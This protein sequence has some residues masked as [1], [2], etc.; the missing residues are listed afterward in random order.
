MAAPPATSVAAMLV[1]LAVNPTA[2]RGR[3]AAAGREL[4]EEIRARGQ[5]VR[6]LAS[7]DA[8]GLRTLVGQAVAGGAERVV[9]AGGDGLVHHLLPVLAGSTTVLGVVGVGSGNDFARGLGLPHDTARALDV[10][11]G[12]W[13]SLD[14][15]RAGDRWVASVATAGFSGAVNA[16][17]NHLRWPRGAQRYTVAT[18]VELPRLRP[19]PLVLRADGEV[20]EQGCTL[21]AVA[22]TP[23]FGG[24]MAICPQARPDDGVLEVTVVEPVSPITLAR[25]FPLVFAGRHLD[26]PAVRTA[27]GR[28]V[29]L[30]AHGVELW[31]DGEPVGPLPVRLECVPGAVRVA[32]P[33]PRPDGAV[34]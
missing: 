20:L 2:N 18:L 30:E 19:F 8:V 11:L 14:A 17:A 23:H 27:R 34:T 4:A 1:H 29:E 9:V 22:N 16:R 3:G 6:V 26:H 13:R 12:P 31:G 21:V 7:A 5:E 28:V 32:A 24:G 25:F 15:M 33:D 10:A